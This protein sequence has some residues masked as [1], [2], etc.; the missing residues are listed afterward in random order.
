MNRTGRA[1]FAQE[2]FYF[3]NE[4]Q[5]GNPAYVVSFALRFEGSLN[6]E[7]L[8][9]TLRRVA[10]EH[11]VLHTGFAVVDG[12]LMQ[13]VRQ[14]AQPELTVLDRGPAARVDQDRF[15]RELVEAEARRPF[16]LGE[17]AVLR[18]W[19]VSWDADQH[20]LVI[21]MHHIACD[22]WTNGLLLEE[23]AEQ[24]NTGRSASEPPALSYIEYA[25]TQ[26]EAWSKDTK[27]LEHWRR[28][29]DGAPQLSLHTDRPRPSVLTYAGSVLRRPLEPAL[30]ER[31][32]AWAKAHGVTTFAVALAAYAQ[33]LARHARQQ[34][35]VVGVPVANRIDEDEERLVGCLV[36][37]LPIRVDLSGR[38]GFEELAV[39]TW[40]TA[41]AALGR[42]DT[43][44]EQI[45]QAAGEQRRLSRAPLFQTM[46]TVQNLAFTM[47]DFDGL[48]VEEVPVEI[49]AAKFDIAVT[50]DVTSEE[51]FLRAEY[52][53]ELF[54]E[55]TVEGLLTHYHTLLA[56]VVSGS[57]GTG[58]VDGSDGEPDMV[59]PEEHRQVTDGWN[60]P[61]EQEQP[62]HPSV[63]KA[64][65]ENAA[66]TPDAVALV[67]R[68]NRLS[69]REL[70]EW[71]DRIAA[72]LAAAGVA[73]GGRVGLL[74]GRS[75]AIV[76]AIIG[77]WK[78][79][80]VYVPL[81]PE[82]P[83]NRLDLILGSAHPAVVVFEPETRALAQELAGSGG[84]TLLDAHAADGVFTGGARFPE[85][86]DLAY[87]MYTSGSTGVPKGVMVP[88]RGLNALCDPTPAG[89]EIDAADRW[90]GVHSFSFDI[91]VW[92]VWGSLSSGGCLIIADHA[93]L[94]DPERLARLV[95]AEEIT[96]LSVTPGVV[97]R[98]L[99]AFFDTL[100]RQTSTV[101]YV[102]LCGEPLSWPQLA[103]MVD[104][105]RLPAL[106]LNMY[107]PT[108]A[109]IYTTMVQVPAA[110]LHEVRDG[111]IGVALPSGRCYVL[112]DRRRP[113]GV[114]VPGELYIGGDLV[115]AGYV[116]MP[117]LTAERFTENP[118]A[119]GMLYKTG[120][121]VRWAHTGTL[122]YIG[123]EDTQVKVRGFRVELA[124][125]ES[126]FLRR[127]GVRSCVAAVQDDQL[128]VFLCT[129]PGFPG[130]QALRGSVRDDLPDYM[131]PTRV[132]VVP[133]I[134]LN[135][136]GKVDTRR[137]VAE[138]WT[139]APAPAVTP[140]FPRPAV[141]DGLGG[142]PGGRDALVSR[143]REIWAEVLGRPDLEPTENFFDAGGHSFALITL[144]Q[145]MAQT[146]LEISVTDLFRYAT[147]AAC[148]AHFR[149]AQ[150]P[151]AEDRAAQ[152]KR[153]RDELARR[154]RAGRE[155]AHA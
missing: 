17:G 46:L 51:P 34:E 130:E 8:A 29:L 142:A 151:L 77:A 54:E 61:I 125:V 108:E 105:E 39:R 116:G 117:E 113:V 38:P 1:S 22:G 132:I 140:A 80:G 10:A 112:D 75:P 53:T 31:V 115:A 49:P 135:G 47:P 111:D 48:K 97:Y 2:R 56:S 44:F 20:A 137:L 149:R 93:D 33:V 9:A 21:M 27:A 81:A 153:G 32:G 109:T 121:I 83:R 67:H 119:P 73:E 96:V 88:H 87:I 133:E 15:L 3:L 89:L 58:G 148:A 147:V 86:D 104:P 84:F 79:G 122:I 144:Q 139:K 62:Y 103:S 25:E 150:T 14:D 7:A 74:L 131:V 82:Y 90:L 114:N 23:I 42:Q 126:A 94:L 91:S 12:V 37:T 72:D 11:D 143:I 110:K 100:E 136:S 66:R 145:R 68:G 50:L 76:A 70:D 120:D 40:R 69:Y 155:D 45:V 118:Y 95:H 154:R 141:G 16:S 4:L 127:P 71:S 24:Y 36:N 57:D 52:S 59:G 64:F 5:P 60:P 146:G 99:P 35:V 129:G 30:V 78:V 134:P 152:R 107:G 102:V 101:R 55:A 63:L 13:Q 19:I 98:L 123:R 138:W 18:A 92:E 43:P 41:M 106:F 124:D 128:G 6:Q 26:R 85:Q 28:V 65:C